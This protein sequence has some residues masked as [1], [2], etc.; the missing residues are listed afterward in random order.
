MYCLLSLDGV[1]VART[2]AKAEGR[3]QEGAYSWDAEFRFEYV[4]FAFVVDKLCMHWQAS[5]LTTYFHFVDSRPSP[6][7]LLFPALPLPPLPT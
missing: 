4:A 7:F 6:F 2:T 1:T 3:G 5:L